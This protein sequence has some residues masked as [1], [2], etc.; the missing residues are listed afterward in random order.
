MIS[1]IVLLVHGDEKDAARITSEHFF[2][3]SQSLV[4]VIDDLSCFQIIILRPQRLFI[5][6]SRA[7]RTGVTSPGDSIGI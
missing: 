2:M 3:R 5:L 7:I 1:L 4:T 6:V